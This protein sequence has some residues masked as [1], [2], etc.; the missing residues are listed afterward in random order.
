MDEIKL[1]KYD[2]HILHALKKDARQTMARL[3]D[4]FGIPRATIHERISRMKKAGVIKRFT[5]EEDYHK[6]GLQTL[7]FVFVEYD[8]RSKLR[9]KDVARELAHVS[10][11]VGVYML[12]GEWDFLLKIRAR[13][14]EEIGNLV[15]DRIHM[16]PG[17]LKTSALACFEVTKDDV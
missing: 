8:P 12:S 17:I 15:M 1:D 2:H 9:Q 13:S 4:R 7:S 3:S 5:I 14:I 6:T 11:V 10:G 16:M